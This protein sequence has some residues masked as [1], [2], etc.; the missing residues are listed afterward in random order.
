[1]TN[2]SSAF[3][4]KQSLVFLIAAIGAAVYL[5]A[6]GAYIAGGVVF[7]LT[8]LGLFVQGGGESACEKIF[9]DPLIR[10][11]R[12][13]LIK[14]GRGELSDRI[15]HIPDDHVLQ[16]V[17]WGINDLLDQTEQMLR[18][19][20]A[21][22]DAANEGKHYRKI[23]IEGYKGDF[24]ASIPELNRAIGSIAD[25]YKTKMRGE[26]AKMFEKRT[27]GIGKGLHVIQEDINRN[28]DIIEKITDNTQET[29]NEAMAS[30]ETVRAI[31]G[32]L[33]NLIQLIAHTNEAIVSLNERT[34]EISA[35]VNLIKDIADQTNLL[36]LNAAI[37]AAR[38]GEH[39][40]GFAV[41]AD[42]VRKLAER[43]QKAT[44]EIAIT[45]QTLQQEANDIQGN[46]EEVT[47]IA[48]SSQEDVN[49]F[50]ETLDK[51]AHTADL[52]AKQ[53]KYIHDSLFAT[54]VKVDH[55]IFKSNAY[56]TVL[57]EDAEKANH[58]TDEHHCRFGKW[59]Y[60]GKGKELFGHTSVYKAVE[61]PHA[62]IHQMVLE[63]VPCAKTHTCLTPENRPKIVENFSKMENASDQLF[64]LLRDMVK[65]ANPEAHIS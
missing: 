6:T 12:D 58:F 40:R 52:A 64:T 17:A 11:V 26:L 1:M 33:D 41:V 32:S 47:Q 19:I 45:I 18:D 65:E 24:K 35:V 36:A 34:G 21:S 59:Y 53:A 60:E 28:T 48:T 31:V 56:T 37:E 61:T 14:A 43:T 7:A 38:A 20:R 22:I 27:G 16:G 63:T 2:L 25:G 5:L 13:V 62:T 49:R 3:S 44:Q 57:N 23:P 54:L 8:L 10:Q 29:A 9:N 42:E 46:S 4:N 30:Q 15:T 55:I 51:F 50:E 39:G